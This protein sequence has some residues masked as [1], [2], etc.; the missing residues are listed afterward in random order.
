MG[1]GSNRGGRGNRR[2]AAHNAVKKQTAG[3]HGLLDIGR[4]W[5]AGLGAHGAVLRE[6]E[7]VGSTSWR[8]GSWRAGAWRRSLATSGM[9][10]QGRWVGSVGAS[11]GGSGRALA[12]RRP[13]AAWAGMGA[14]RQRERGEGRSVLGPGGAHC[15]REE[16]GRGIRGRRWWL[17][18]RSEGGAGAGL[19]QGA[20]R[21]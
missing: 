19:G 4:G 8:V 14:A 2:I 17:A 7:A 3:S 20:V 5:P 13:S 18:G 6:V 11:A 16:G 1:R 15:E 12:W 9:S 21:G 10:G